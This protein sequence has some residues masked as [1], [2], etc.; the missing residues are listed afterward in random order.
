MS[1]SG[2][3]NNPYGRPQPHPYG[4]GPAPQNP[5]PAQQNPY[6]QQPPP[7]GPPGGYGYPA[8]GTPL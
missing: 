3:Q 1:I 5:V 8:A 4:Q 6:V 2:D 7:Q